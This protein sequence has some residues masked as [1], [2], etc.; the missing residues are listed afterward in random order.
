MTEHAVID[1]SVTPAETEMALKQDLEYDPS[2]LPSLVIECIFE[3]YIEMGV[4]DQA[5]LWDAQLWLAQQRPLIGSA[6]FCSAAKR[7]HRQMGPLV[8]GMPI[9][10]WP[11]IDR[12]PNRLIQSSVTFIAGL[13]GPSGKTTCMCALAREYSMAADGERGDAPECPPM[14]IVAIPGYFVLALREHIAWAT[15]QT[16]R[17]VALSYESLILRA[18]PNVTHNFVTDI[19][20]IVRSMSNVHLM[21][22]VSMTQEIT[23]T[24]VTSGVDRVVVVTGPATA[25]DRACLAKYVAEMLGASPKALGPF[26]D[27]LPAYTQL[28]LERRPGCTR[29]DPLHYGNTLILIKPPATLSHI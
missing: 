29:D 9:S 3:H 22:S 15:P 26:I 8:A 17:I 1:R 18:V 24:Y 2:L 20:K 19:V 21:L 12:A 6:E 16:D 7:T 28:V 5:T 14:P 27:A 10:S 23:D 13:S 11:G 25:P 4:R